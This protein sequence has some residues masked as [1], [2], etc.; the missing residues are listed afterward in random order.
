MLFTQQI[1]NKTMK[2]T[3]VMITKNAGEVIEEALKRVAG[4]WDE[5]LVSDQSST[6]KTVE[7]IK[8]YG[9]KV[10]PTEDPNLGKRKQWLL[11]QAKGDWILVLDSDERLSPQLRRE[12]ASIVKTDSGQTISGYRLAYQNYLFGEPVFT[13]GED[14]AK[15]RLF[16]RGKAK[17]TPLPVHEEV[18]V[19]GKISTLRGKVLHYSYRSLGQLFSKFTQYAKLEVR[20]KVLKKEKVTP[21]KLFLY[22]PHMFWARFIKDRGYKD[23]WRGFILAFA[24][25]YMEW[26]TYWLLFFRSLA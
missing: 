24:F 23:G 6:D 17:I 19:V 1:L 18:Q 9:G 16:R 11:D 20:Q 14:Y 2:L 12:I 15:V 10:F 25:G 26:L 13:G 3:V 7:I 21:A 22:A 8:R 5:L 4:L